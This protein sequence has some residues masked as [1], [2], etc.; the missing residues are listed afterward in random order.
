MYGA[1]HIRDAGISQGLHSS[2]SP[3]RRDGD[4]SMTGDRCRAHE[5]GLGAITDRGALKNPR[6]C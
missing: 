4:D 3:A 6:R 5:M 1:R 2:V